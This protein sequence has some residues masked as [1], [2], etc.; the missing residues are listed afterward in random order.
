[1]CLPVS[2]SQEHTCTWGACIGRKEVLAGGGAQASITRGRGESLGLH[3]TRSSRNTYL[4]KVIRMPPNPAGWMGHPACYHV[5]HI[6]Q[7]GST[8]VRT[9]DRI[10]E[11]IQPD[12]H[13]RSKADVCNTR[14]DLGQ[15]PAHGTTIRKTRE[16]LTRC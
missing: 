8:Q 11:G 14:A 9:R 1:M 16:T 4:G 12:P 5:N 15:V 3:P 6:Q 13:N 10:D 2:H 7:A